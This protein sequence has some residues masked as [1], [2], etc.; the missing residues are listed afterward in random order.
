MNN[1]LQD[2]ELNCIGNN[3]VVAG[4]ECKDEPG[5]RF[6]YKLDDMVIKHRDFMWVIE[7]PVYGAAEYLTIMEIL[8][9]EYW[10]WEE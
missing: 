9:N 6:I 8:S 1:C 7:D 4:F 10:R 3:L 2:R 5:H